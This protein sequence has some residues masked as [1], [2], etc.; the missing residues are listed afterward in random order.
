M[1]G[2]VHGQNV[3]ANHRRFRQWLA[4]L[5]GVASHY[6]PN[7]LGWQWALDGERIATPERFLRATIGLFH[8]Q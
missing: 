7:Y 1:R 8:T 2:A 5:H 3:N 4:R 6:L